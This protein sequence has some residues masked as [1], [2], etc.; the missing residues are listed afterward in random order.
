MLV[1][2]SKRRFGEALTDDQPPARGLDLDPGLGLYLSR[3]LVREQ[4]GGIELDTEQGR[5]TTMFV[6]LPAADLAR[7]EA[8][9]VH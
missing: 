6:T 2:R 8:P 3:E 1:T 7:R 4:G 9:P 5:G